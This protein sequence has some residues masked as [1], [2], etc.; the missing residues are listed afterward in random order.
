[1]L[2]FGSPEH[3]VR[4]VRVGDFRFRV[5]GYFIRQ[6]GVVFLKGVGDILEEGKAQDDMLVF[7]GLP[8]LGFNPRG[9]TISYCFFLTLECV[10]K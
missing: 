8:E 1:M 2:F 5:L 4:P 7:G 9:E 6:L 10:L 3:I